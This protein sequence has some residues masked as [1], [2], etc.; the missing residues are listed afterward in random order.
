MSHRRSGS[1]TTVTYA[2]KQYWSHDAMASSPGASA[3]PLTLPSSDL[4]RYLD[5]NGQR[6]GESESR[7]LEPWRKAGPR[8]GKGLTRFLARWTHPVILVF[9]L[10][11][12]INIDLMQRSRVDYPTL[13]CLAESGFV[14]VGRSIAVAEYNLN[15]ISSSLVYSFHYKHK[16]LQC[17]LCDKIC[18]SQYSTQEIAQTEKQRLSSQPPRIKKGKRKPKRPSGLRTGT[19]QFSLSTIL[20]GEHT[21]IL[22][23]PSP[24]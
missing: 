4:T 6:R 1:L 15:P 8:N 3:D 20:V 2:G 13:P 12:F 24:Y 16:T 10:N 11:L 22:P 5:L 9:K 21:V 7:D 17:L 19:L 23:F 18:V 14:Q